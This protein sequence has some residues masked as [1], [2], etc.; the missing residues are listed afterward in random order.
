MATA[1]ASEL[2]RGAI[3]S[4]RLLVWSLA[5][6]PVLC[7]LT[8][9]RVFQ[10]PHLLDLVGVSSPATQDVFASQVYRLLMLA[11]A[12]IAGGLAVAW[13]HNLTRVAL[14]SPLLLAGAGLAFSLLAA[15]ILGTRPR[16][17]PGLLVW[18]LLFAAIAA[19]PQIGCDAVLTLLRSGLRM[20]VVLSVLSAL[21]TPGWGLESDY[22]QSYIPGW[23]WRLHG[24]LPHANS[25]G[26]ACAILLLLE[27]HGPSARR[28]AWALLAGGALL[29]TQSKTSILAGTVAA[30]LLLGFQAFAVLRARLDP[31]LGLMAAGLAM[32]LAATVGMMLWPLVAERANDLF[33]DRGEEIRSLTGRTELWRITMDTWRAN[34][35]FGDG[36]GLWDREMQERHASELGWRPGHAHNQLVQALGQAGCAGLAAWLAYMLV[37]AWASWRAPKGRAGLCWGL[38]VVVVTASQ[39]EPWF[40]RDLPAKLPLLLYVHIAFTAALMPH[41]REPPA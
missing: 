20:I 18:P 9:P 25:L 19:L 39:S 11:L 40:S 2:P 36:A 8:S 23:T 17:A 38:L 24:V 32:A 29:A 15:A 30:P 6:C 10:A 26:P 28:W 21:A 3:G 33:A 34:P 4:W 16:I 13:R 35:W 37:L 31:R 27:L 41:R 14:R 22:G 5:A 1:S 12:L 7:G